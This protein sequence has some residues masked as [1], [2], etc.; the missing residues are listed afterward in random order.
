[1]EFLI[2]KFVVVLQ[3]NKHWLSAVFVYGLSYPF[4]EKETNIQCDVAQRPTGN[5]PAE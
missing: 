2:G 4:L 3:D 1:M 5:V